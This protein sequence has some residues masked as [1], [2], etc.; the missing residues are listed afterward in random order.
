MRN[1]I[2]SLA[3]LVAA[4]L[5]A[6]ALQATPLEHQATSSE[7]PI[8]YRLSFPQPEHRWMQVEVLFP[9]V[10]TAPLAVRMSRSSPGRYAL[11][12]FAKNV[13]DVHAFEGAGKELTITRPDAHQWDV[14][15]HDGAVRFVYKVYGDRV[16]GT[17]LGIDSTHAHINMPAALVWARGFEGRPA[18]VRFER[19]TGS[20]WQVATQLYPSD[21]PLVFTAPNLQYLLDSPA[22]FSSFSLRTFTVADP[23]RV[24]GGPTFRLAVHHDGSEAQLDRFAVDVETIVRESVAIFGEFPEYEP[25]TY[26]FIADYLWYASGDGMEHR[27]STVLTSSGSLENQ[28]RGLLSTVAHELFHSWNVERIRPQALEPFDFERANVSGELWLGEG[29]TSYYDDLIMAR[30]GLANLSE[31]VASVS[32]VINAV[33]HSPARRL[34]SVVEMSRLAPFTDA[35][36]AIDR[37]N[38]GNTFISYYTWGAAIGLGLDLS[39]RARADP[40]GAGDIVSGPGMVSLDDYMRAMWQAHGEPGGPAPGLVEVPYT[41]GDAR[42]RLAEIT[43]DRAF[44]DDF[45]DRYVEG[46]EVVDYARLLERAGL[47]LRKRAPGRAWLGDVRLAF[48]DDGARVTAPVP[49]GSPMY[50]AGLELDDLVVSFDGETNLRSQRRFTQSLTNRRPGDRV[51]VKFLRRGTPTT[52]TVVLEEDPRLELLP[53]ETVGERLTDNQRAFRAAWLGSKVRN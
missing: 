19:P 18:Q 14:R 47:M 26:T 1:P 17:Y 27:N 36:R 9:Q 37:T 2:R 50:A 30:A 40:G 25:G 43:S 29:F 34:R 12:E 35:A 4:A 45:F 5:S 3:F 15:G 49:F 23:S 6:V 8:R 32:R 48:G 52:A 38:W 28:R 10:G 33:Q 11:H 7:A 42:D 44:V 21:D 24:G 13:Y 53:I 41:L 20:M 31:T 51:F 22:E 39:L 46:H 16:D